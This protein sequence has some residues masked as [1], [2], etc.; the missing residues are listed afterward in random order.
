MDRDLPTEE[1]DGEAGERRQGRNL[2]DHASLL[3]QTRRR[4]TKATA[5][6]EPRADHAATQDDQP[7]P[8]HRLG[9]HGL[10]QHHAEA[11]G[12]A[13]PPPTMAPMS[14][15]EMPSRSATAIVGSADGS[16]SRQKIAAGPA[17]KERISATFC[18]SQAR[19]PAWVFTVTG[20]K[21]R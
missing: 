12:V 16:R 14:P 19:I 7:Q 20:K 6:V 5:P 21:V 8:H 13:E 17:P 2:A 15:S 3:H 9:V 10:D 18:G 11:D 1:E 4:S